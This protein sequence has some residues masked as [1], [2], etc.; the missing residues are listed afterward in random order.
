MLLDYYI[1]KYLLAKNVSVKK[2]KFCLSIINGSVYTILYFSIYRQ[3]NK[4][5]IGI[6]I[7]LGI[8]IIFQ[9]YRTKKLRS[10]F[11]ETEI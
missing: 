10:F 6:I 1:A 9:I 7:F 11:R 4:S 2:I 5:V 8:I 3:I